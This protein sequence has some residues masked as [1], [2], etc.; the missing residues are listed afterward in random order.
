MRHPPGKEM[1]QRARRLRGEMT[2]AERLL[3]S[4]L[5][6]GQ[7]G[8]KFRSQMWLGGAIADFACIQA[9]LVIEVDGGQHDR[10][11]RKDERRARAMAALGYRTIRFWNHDVLENID[12]VLRVIEDALPSPSHP[13]ARGGPLPLPGTGEGR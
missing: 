5:R 8:V 10:D 2:D 7:L 3:W 4:R 1:V 6:A 12:G 9:R 13:A 11:R